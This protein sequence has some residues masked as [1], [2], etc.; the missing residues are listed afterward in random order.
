MG[1]SCQKTCGSLGQMHDDA[2]VGGGLFLRSVMQFSVWLGT[3]DWCGLIPCGMGSQPGKLMDPSSSMIP[4]SKTYD[5]NDSDSTS[6]GNSTSE[7]S[8]DR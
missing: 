5:A 7:H 1:S 6:A 8:S 4:A 3:L 2:C